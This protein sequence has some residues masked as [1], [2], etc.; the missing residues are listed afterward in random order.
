MSLSKRLEDIKDEVSKV[1]LEANKKGYEIDLERIII[2]M[3]SASNSL[4]YYE[5]QDSGD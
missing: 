2:L 5:E 3:D 1:Q 4:R